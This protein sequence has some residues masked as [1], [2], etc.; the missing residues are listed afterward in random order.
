MNKAYKTSSSQRLYPESSD[1]THA[2]RQVSWLT[3]HASPSH[4]LKEQMHQRGTVALLMHAFFNEAYSCGDSSGISPDSLLKHTYVLPTACK[5]KLHN[6]S[7]AGK[8]ICP[9]KYSY[10]LKVLVFVTQLETGII[11]GQAM[12]TLFSTSCRPPGQ[13]NKLF[14]SFICSYNNLVYQ[15]QIVYIQNS[16]VK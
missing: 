12:S 8:P 9:F 5:T 15:H 7:T 10:A 4:S 13:A 2:S 3:S 11:P 14:M 16:I 1:A 6:K